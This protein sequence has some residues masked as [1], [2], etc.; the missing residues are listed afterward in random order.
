MVEVRDTLARGEKKNRFLE[1]SQAPPVCPRD[2][3]SVNVKTLGSLG[4]EA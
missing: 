3:D 2:K 1:G 4:A